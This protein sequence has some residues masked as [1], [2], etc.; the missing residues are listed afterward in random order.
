MSP[1][2]TC[3]DCGAILPADAPRGLCPKC[4]IGAACSRTSMSPFTATGAFELTGQGILATI[5]QSIGPVPRVLL[6]DT[7]GGAEP[8]VVRLPGWQTPTSR[9]ATGSTNRH[10]D[11]ILTPVPEVVCE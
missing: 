10:R 7:D 6:R 8:P 9:S 11:R 1:E 2:R 3:P 5:A 4:L